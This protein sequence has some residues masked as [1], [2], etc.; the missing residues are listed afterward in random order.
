MR[1][2]ASDATLG[3]QPILDRHGQVVAYEL[4]FRASTEDVDARISDDAVATAS[5]VACAFEKRGICTVV[6]KAQ[7]FVNV[8]AAWLDGS[9]VER[10]HHDDV[11]LEILETVDVDAQ[12]LRR[13]RN[14]KD[15]GY[16][17]AL[18]DFTHDSTRHEPLLDIVD[19]VK[20]D[21]LQSDTASLPGLVQRL[22][23]WPVQLLAEKVDTL[24]RA[25]QCVALGF[26]L[27]QGFF[28]GRPLVLRARPCMTEPRP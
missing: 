28:F 9:A 12:I 20:V 17:L 7:A 27:Y 25:R 18:D 1:T 14:L 22:K 15:K 16:R 24:E 8:D 10:I 11:V 26:D 6:G 13:C 23:R 5:V 19:I 4:L 21:V 3:R 2:H